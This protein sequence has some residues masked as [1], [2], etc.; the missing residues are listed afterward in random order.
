MALVGL[1]MG[2]ASAKPTTP[3]PARQES[4]EETVIRQLNDVTGQFFSLAGLGKMDEA[5]KLVSQRADRD[6][7]DKMR[8]FIQRYVGK[9][10]TSQDHVVFRSVCSL[11]WK[12]ADK[13]EARV[14]A[15]VKNDRH[16]SYMDKSVTYTWTFVR[17]DGKWKLLSMNL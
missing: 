11:A 3:A 15:T 8:H 6:Q 12:S 7:I 5:M 10:D 2:C 13:A 4:E 16:F 1:L 17:E 9:A 14:C